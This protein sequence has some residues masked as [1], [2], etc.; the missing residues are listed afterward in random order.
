LGAG[1][2]K[3]VY[4]PEKELPDE[5]DQELAEAEMVESMRE[6]PGQ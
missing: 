5:P 4:E 2:K 6:P 1:F 3:H